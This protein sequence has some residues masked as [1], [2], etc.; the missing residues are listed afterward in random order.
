M[1]YTLI[2]HRYFPFVGGSERY[3]QELAEYLAANSHDV[4]MLTTVAHD[5]EY[6]WD[7]TRREVD[8]PA[9]ENL[10]GV[11]VARLPIRH[12]PGNTQLFPAARRTMGEASRV[13]RWAA[14]FTQI[15][16]FLPAIPSLR[17]ELAAGGPADVIHGTNLSLEGPA[18]VGRDFAQLCGVP[19]V[20]TPFIH[21]GVPGDPIARRY[22]SM[23]HQVQL[24]RDADL[25]I[26]MTELE[27]RHIV[28]LSIDEKRVAV[29]GVGVRP[30][31]VRGG[32]GAAFRREHGVDGYLVAS[33]GAM[34]ADKGTFDTVRAV[35]E[36]RRR[37]VDV[38]LVLAGPALSGFERWFAALDEG[39]RQG[40]HLL[41]FINA[42]EK[43][44]LLAAMDALVV[45]SRTE[46]FG[47]V[48]LEAWANGKPVIAAAAG[49]V[50]ELVKNGQNGLLVPFGDPLQLA[51]AIRTLVDEPHT[52]LDFGRRGYDLTV[53]RYTWT[54]V[55]DRLDAAHERVLGIRISESDGK[56]LRSNLG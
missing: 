35:V 9:R 7:P 26:A 21:L 41:G 19:F 25:V 55:L 54:A 43:R 24:L 46:S 49:A 42:Q 28:G 10:N 4:S 52:G 48:Y 27:R 32:D 39:D 5:L 38:E 30:D 22:V 11:D 50:T 1:R 13:V 18:I 2:N 45:P 31:E 17:H 16:R 23:P 33:L 40:I 3:V 14:P 53:G 36:L 29:S 6:F 15:S 8:A 34:A 51:E 56:D 20:L 37:G 12:L 44:D 47:I